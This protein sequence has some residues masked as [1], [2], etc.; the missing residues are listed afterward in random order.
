MSVTVM[1]PGSEGAGQVYTGDILH[2][3][4]ET[5][6][7]PGN[8]LQVTVEQPEF[9]PTSKH[10]PRSPTGGSRTVVVIAPENGSMNRYEADFPTGDWNCGEY[11]IIVTGI[12]V[13]VMDEHP[14]T[15]VCRQ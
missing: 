7:S 6:L 11:T 2:V 12:D 15:L 10:D 9:G 8:R 4:G 3:E 14:F 5:I 1:V 13:P